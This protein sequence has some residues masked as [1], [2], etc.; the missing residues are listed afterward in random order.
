LE[1]TEITFITTDASEKKVVLNTIRRTDDIGNS[2]LLEGIFPE[3]KIKIRAHYLMKPVAGDES[4]KEQIEW[5]SN[6]TY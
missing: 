3:S 5:Q 2:F 6:I 1:G 4:Y